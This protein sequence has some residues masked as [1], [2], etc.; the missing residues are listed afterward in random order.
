[1]LEEKTQGNRTP[2]E[3][4][5]LSRLLHELRMTYVAVQSGAAGSGSE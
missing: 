2:E 5:L 1:M 3:I 4:S